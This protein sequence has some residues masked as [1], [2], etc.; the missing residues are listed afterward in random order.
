MG[1]D[2]ARSQQKWINIGVQ[3]TCPTQVQ[4]V[5]DQILL[6]MGSVFLCVSNICDQLLDSVANTYIRKS[7]SFRFV[8]WGFPFFGIP[9]YD[10]SK[11][12]KTMP[13]FGRYAEMGSHNL[14]FGIEW[15]R[16]AMDEGDFL[17]AFGGHFS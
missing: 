15:P 7:Y 5:R 16:L 11:S 13:T 6:N 3:L 8:S 17:V 9:D 14:T 4:P 2:H 1:N 12:I 10:T